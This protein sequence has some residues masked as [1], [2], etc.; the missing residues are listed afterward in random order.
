MFQSPEILDSQLGEKIKCIFVTNYSDIIG[1]NEAIEAYKIDDVGR[2]IFGCMAGPSCEWENLIHEICHF[3]ELPLK[4]LLARPQYGW[5]LSPGGFIQV[6]FG[7]LF[8]EAMTDQGVR[9]EA[10][11]WALQANICE[12]L[13]MQPHVTEWAKSAKYVNA[14]G[15][16]SLNFKDEEEN[17]RLREEKATLGLASYIN[18]LRKKPKYQAETAIQRFQKRVELLRNIPVVDFPV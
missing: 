18:E 7:Q 2:F 12:Y 14:W 16:W 4:R 13:G 8:Q 11:V 6:V 17:Y 3:I 15:M 5:G 1:I 9:R 10:R